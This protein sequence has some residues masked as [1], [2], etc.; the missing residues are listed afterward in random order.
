MEASY[1]NMMKMLKIE[2]NRNKGLSVLHE[3]LVLS[4][5]TQEFTVIV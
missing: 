2:E 5:T 1:Q 3:H 4:A